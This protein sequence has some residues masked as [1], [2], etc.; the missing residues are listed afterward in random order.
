MST[1]TSSGF[2]IGELAK[3]AQVNVETIR[4]YQKRG[5][6]PEIKTPEVGYKRYPVEMLK[7]IAFIKSAQ[8]LAF[9]LSEIKVLLD[10]NDVAN[11]KEKIRAV[12]HE[13]LEQVQ[14][15]KKHLALVEK[16]LK[17]WIHTCETSDPQTPCP[18]INHI[19]QT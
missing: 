7:R 13:R 10:L 14:Q 6:L 4:Y 18:I 5:L 1:C 16:T 8:H 2:T 11:D 17:E 9:S 15:T 3:T 19:Q 12:A